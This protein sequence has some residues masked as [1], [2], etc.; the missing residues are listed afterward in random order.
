MLHHVRLF[1]RSTDPAAG[2][3]TDVHHSDSEESLH[4]FVRHWLRFGGIEY[5]ASQG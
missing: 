4:Q 2:G 3:V 1:A 5:V